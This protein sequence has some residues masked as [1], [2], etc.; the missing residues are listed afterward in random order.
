MSNPPTIDRE[1]NGK[2]VCTVSFTAEEAAAS[3]AK[4]VQ[5]LGSSVKI[6]GFRSGS[7]P[8]E[9]LKEKVDPGQLFEETVRELL[10]DTFTALV[11]E[12]GIKPIIPP[13]IEI[14]NDKPITVKVIFVER[15]IVKVKNGSKITVK[16]GETTVDEKDLQQMI[17]YI[18]KQHQKSKAV[19]RAAKEDDRI[20]MD[21]WGE[22]ED[23][24]EIEEIRTVGHQVVIGSKV[25]L[26]GFEDELKGLKKD[27]TK[28]FTLS[29]PEKH[30]TEE[31]RGKPV[32]FHVTIKNIEEVTLPE[33]TDA[34]AKE[35]LKVA[36]VE[37]FKK[38][39]KESMSMQEE[40]MQKRKTEEEA[41]EKIREATTVKL[42]PE[43]I[44]DEQ[45]SLL[46]DLMQQLDKQ[47]MNLEEWIERTGKTQEQVQ[48]ELEDQAK[49]RLTLR[50]GIAALMEEKGIDITEEEM[51]KNINTLLSPL[52]VEERL[53]I[54]PSYAK[55]GNAYEQLEWQKKV[56]KLLEEI[57]S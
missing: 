46:E 45:R 13:K 28:D 7:A 36:S 12:H 52:S 57:I 55:G 10:P 17:D 4:A 47:S 30:Q 16:V 6:D 35:N 43:L 3:E 33:L 26:P 5:K 31:L 2:V 8:T 18:L 39:V 50:L 14:I 20:T 49:K 23:G 25:L 21:F 38:Q 56:E 34:F 40:E 1:D 48:S 53:K 24:K 44:E 42:V 11:Q 19:D 29:F 15:P 51:K 27:D 54:A 22:G 41:F 32:T 9:V 37:E